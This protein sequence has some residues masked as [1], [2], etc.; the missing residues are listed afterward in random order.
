MS[1]R[2]ISF[3]KDDKPEV[4]VQI[5]LIRQLAS[6]YS[7]DSP[8]DMDETALL[9]KLKPDRTLATHAGSG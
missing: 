8:L 5:E 3:C 7:D 9:W 6:A 1:I 4:I 2:G